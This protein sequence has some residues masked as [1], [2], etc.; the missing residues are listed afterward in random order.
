MDLGCDQNALFIE[1][2]AE[3]VTVA[4]SP[5]G[6]Q[7]TLASDNG[8]VRWWNKES[9]TIDFALKGHTHFVWSA[10]YLPDRKQLVS[11]SRDR[12]V[13]FWEPLTGHPSAVLQSPEV[14][15]LALSPN[16][17]TIASDEG[18]AT[19]SFGIRLPESPVLCSVVTV[20]PSVASNSLPM[21]KGSLHPAMISQV[22]L[23]D[24]LIGM[25]IFS[26]LG[27]HNSSVY[28][29]LFSRRA[30][31]RFRGRGLKVRL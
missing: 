5:C 4:F 23:W 17:L 12:T 14:V 20:R 6:K 29:Y 9:G 25:P 22:R 1:G 27:N 3:R 13:R 31:S 18:D 21:A 2:H 28:H 16:K 15:C 8:M 24:V 30:T 26:V 19:F 7:V 11:G 10:I